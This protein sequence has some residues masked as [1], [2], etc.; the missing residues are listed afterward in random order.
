MAYCTADDLLVGNIPLPAYLDVNAVIEDAA[1]EI[2]SKIGWR[3]VTPIDISEP[4]PL[5]RPARL[6][7]K[8]INA[9]LATGRLIL[10]V[11]SPEEKNNL[12]A[13]GWSLVREANGAINV[14][15]D[16]TV[17]LEGAT[18]VDPAIDDEPVAVPLINNLDSESQVEAFYDRV[19]NPDY[20]YPGIY[21][22]Y[23][24]NP[25]SLVD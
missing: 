5:V 24:S 25:D 23:T 15:A 10:A 22:R 9:A 11:A 3:Y 7:L 4:G 8:R 19:A 6:M 20:F 16:G 17:P 12:H 18:L 13:Y 14:I 1:D 2:D 21:P